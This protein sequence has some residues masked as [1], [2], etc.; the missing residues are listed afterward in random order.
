[1]ILLLERYNDFKDVALM[2]KDSGISLIS[3]F[4][5]NNLMVLSFTF[6]GSHESILTRLST[7]WWLFVVGAL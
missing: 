4:V 7:L 2:K 3:L 6:G 5:C 1:M